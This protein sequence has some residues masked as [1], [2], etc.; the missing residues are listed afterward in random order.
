MTDDEKI[1]KF[2]NENYNKT[3]NLKNL[4]LAL[5]KFLKQVISLRL[6]VVI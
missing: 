2:I 4:A 5:P 6:G 3:L 1:R